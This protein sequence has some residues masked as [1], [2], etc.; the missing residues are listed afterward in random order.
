MTRAASP[1]HPVTPRARTTRGDALGKLL[2]TL[3]PWTIV[4]GKG[5]VGKTTAATAL[6]Q[7][8]AVDE[9]VLLIS[10]DPARTLGSVVGVTLSLEPVAVPDMPGVHAVQL[11][12]EAARTSFL[13]RWRS[14]LL[15]LVDRGT[16]L[17]ESDAASLVD[18]TLPGGDETFAVLR[19]AELVSDARFPRIIVDTAPT[20][21]TLRLL[22]LPA[23]LQAL[24]G[25]L[26]AFQEKHRMLV[27]A[28]R[29]RYQQDDA[30]RFLADLRGQIESL[31]SMLH[32]SSSCAAVVVTR[33]EAMVTEESVRLCEALRTRKIRLGAI[34]VNAMPDDVAAVEALAPLRE[35]AGAVPWLVVPR[36]ADAP[37][38]VGGA[39]AWSARVREWKDFARGAPPTGKVAP[40]RA[41]ARTT[42]APRE[43]NS[44]PAPMVRPLTIV[45]GKGGVGKTTL[46]CALAVASADDGHMTL[47]VSTDPAPSVADAFRQT[48]GD[49]VVPVTGIERLSARQLD[50]EASFD[51][52]REAY[53]DRIGDAVRTI[54]PT[55]EGGALDELLA[56]APPGIDELYA[57]TWLGDSIAEREYDRVIVDPAPT[58]HLLRLLELPPIALAWSHELMRLLLKYRNLAPLSDAAEGLLEFAR[59]TR[60]VQAMLHDHERTS[61][62]VAALDEPLVRDETAR[63]VRAV[64]AL[65]I[66]VA[67]VVWNR[68]HSAP[69]P[70][71]LTPPVTQYH[72]LEAPE[73][74]VGV[75]A[76]RDWLADLSELQP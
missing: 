5:G 34:V 44:R 7:R 63:L 26:D 60:A 3:P 65:D 18:A 17:D 38:S 59:R 16:Y 33:P 76:L 56:L 51:R 70:L 11:G 72:L 41:S 40:R 19:L 66:D 22:A 50:A 15:T 32:D 42:T 9:A 28:I 20:G 73:P 6:A 52:F 4:A 58:G 71:A 62:I 45:G 8:A 74:P 35:T 53:G 29:H 61:V 25:L 57:L 1:S 68:A 69:I 2:A 21:H 13:D 24:V 75:N 12:A 47:I 31:E 14:V 37:A 48:I 64:R 49:D 55:T 46:S 54:A 67:G 39:S 10:T 36:L 23:T 43:S 27:R 30:D